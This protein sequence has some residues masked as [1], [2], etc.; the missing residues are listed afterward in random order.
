MAKSPPHQFGQIVGNLLEDILQPMLRKFC[1]ERGLYLDIKGKRAGVRRGKKVIWTDKYGNDHNLDFVI[2]KGGSPKKKGRPVAFIEAAWRRYTRH[3]R[4]KAQ[5]IQGAI[6][7]IAEGH[8]WDKPFLGAVLAGVFTGGS[9]DQ[10]RSVGFRVLYFPYESV[11]FAFRRVG[12]EAR[13]DETTPDDDY[14]KCVL[15]IKALGPEGYEK[16]KSYLAAKEKALFNSFLRELADALDRMIDQLVVVPLF[17][18]QRHFESISETMRFIRGFH[19]TQDGGPFRKYEIIVR[20]SNGD[21][22][23][24]SFQNKQELEKFLKYLSTE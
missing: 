17:G 18:E 5:E 23:N 1:D 14:R 10:L 15:Q 21:A 24:A 4:N 16:L 12:I 20:Y 9:L 6:L 8:E 13:F 22:I 19:E 3:S 11:V 7:P 2:E